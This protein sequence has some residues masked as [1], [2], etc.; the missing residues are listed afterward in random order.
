MRLQLPDILGLGIGFSIGGMALGA[1]LLI[2]AIPERPEAPDPTAPVTPPSTPETRAPAPGLPL[3]LSQMVRPQ[4]QGRPPSPAL[5]QVTRPGAQAAPALPNGVTTLPNV[6]HPTDR[7]RPGNLSGTGFFIA[8]DGTILTAAHVV[9][10]CRTTRIASAFLKPTEA[11]ILAADMRHDLALLRAHVRPP[12][13][14]GL[15]TRP[16][17]NRH[18]LAFGYPANGDVLV[19][20]EAQARARADMAASLGWSRDMSPGMWL[21]AG[22]VRQGFS[23]GP[24]VTPDGEAIGLVKAI[25]LR[26]AI[27]Q[28]AEPTPSGVAIGPDTRTITDFLRREAPEL[29]PGNDWKQHASDTVAARKAVVHVFCLRQS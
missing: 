2:T 17:Q 11:T 15:T 12:A 21:D 20:T 6:V 25:L 19:P 8:A 18:L 28:G 27:T 29:E 9:D 14:L 4:E 24:V 5:P 26:S 1:Y 10:Q 22:E 16:V 3:P 7:T 23:G 13:L